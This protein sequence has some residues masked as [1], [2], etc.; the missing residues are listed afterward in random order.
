MI[1]LV[2]FLEERSAEKMLKG[3]LPRLFGNSINVITIPFEGKQDLE[4]Q[5]ERKMR[6]W[7]R[8][9]SV[10]LVMLDQDAG[11]CLVVKARLLE[12]VQRTG[13]ADKTMVRIACRELESFYLGDMRAVESGL[14]LSGLVRKQNKAK[15]RNPDTI[16]DPSGELMRLTG[17]LYQKVSGSRAIAPHLDF[18]NNVSQSFNTLIRG[19]KRLVENCG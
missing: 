14:N 15:Y 13:K 16:G 9:N 12:K 2:C 5:L 19:I 11:D 18:E 4:K 8:P 3:T 1:N 7:L 10:F 17:G 6:N